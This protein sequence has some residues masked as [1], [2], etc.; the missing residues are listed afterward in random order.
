M[1]IHQPE[2]QKSNGEITITARVETQIPIPGLPETMWFTFPES[3]E[4]W[5][6]DRGD[7]F[8]ACILVSAMYFQEKVEICPTVSPRMAYNL[9]EVMYI[10]HHRSGGKLSP[11]EIKYHNFSKQA[12]EKA[13][14]GVGMTFSG[15]VDSFFTLWSNLPQNQPF[16][17]AR[18][19]H[20][21]FIQG[22]FDLNFHHQTYYNHWLKIYSQ[23]FKEN[24]LQ[25]LQFR[26]NAG[27]FSHPWVDWVYEVI[28]FLVGT[29]MILSKLFKRFYVAS[30]SERPRE[31]IN[32]GTPTTQLLST[33]TLDIF[34]HGLQMNRLEK[35]TAISEWDQARKHLR[36][37]G[38][39]K[40]D[41]TLI[42]CGKCEK[43]LRSI[44]ALN[45]LDLNHQFPSLD[46]SLN[47]GA[48]L[49]YLWV[50][51]DYRKDYIYLIEYATQHHKWGIAFLLRLFRYPGLLKMWLYT[52]FL[53]ML[54][55]DQYLKFK[56]WRT[57]YIEEQPKK[58]L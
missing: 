55:K 57:G 5:I 49:R 30:S 51:K 37:C 2:T 43:C 35:I 36:V 3:Y 19:T 9:D 46:Y 23:L 56:R 28:P 29:S 17:D 41:I 50:N 6:S 38:D 27:H 40:R 52:K 22:I 33:E 45:I 14:D 54:S 39:H 26:T 42:N 8:L 18:L 32:Y 16:Q 25:L 48:W 53:S 1:I 34:Y 47:L 15:G 20:G 44:I 11:T 58:L 21:V 31:Q 4:P 10:I 7:G 13:A 12:P 24:H